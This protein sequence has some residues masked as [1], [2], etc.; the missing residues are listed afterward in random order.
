MDDGEFT[1]P[2]DS[3]T[4]IARH[5]LVRCQGPGGHLRSIDGD[6]GILWAIGRDHRQGDSQV[7]LKLFT[8]TVSPS[9]T[10]SLQ[11]VRDFRN[12]CCMST[13]R[14]MHHTRDVCISRRCRRS[15]VNDTRRSQH[16]TKRC[17]VEL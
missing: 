1:V 2:C 17:I 8:S 5:Y 16:S 15:Q 11:G 3:H 4:Y 12:I 10:L 14:A 7:S 9:P 6:R 13:G